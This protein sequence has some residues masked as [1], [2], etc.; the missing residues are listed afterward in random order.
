M[1]DSE[2]LYIEHVKDKMEAILTSKQYPINQQFI[3]FFA[4]CEDLL[5]LKIQGITDTVKK[6]YDENKNII[7]KIEQAYKKV[8]E[9]VRRKIGIK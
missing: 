4:I 3:A 6:L 9:I 2:K 5:L 1:N 7:E 8:N